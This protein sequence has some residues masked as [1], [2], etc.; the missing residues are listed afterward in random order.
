MLRSFLTGAF[1]MKRI[2]TL[3]IAFFSTLTGGEPLVIGIAGG[4]GSG[5]TTLAQKIQD[6]FPGQSVLISQDSYY[7]DLNGMPIDE[8]AKVNFDHPD[9]LDFS[10][11]VQ[12]LHELR[13]GHTIE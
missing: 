7:K 8:R 2:L 6:A 11:M 5:K 3:L 12:Q 10:L 13:R 4:T 1:C 9:S